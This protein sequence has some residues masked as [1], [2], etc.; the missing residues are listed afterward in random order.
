MRFRFDPEHDELRQVRRLLTESAGWCHAGDSG[1]LDS[2]GL[3]S[4]V[5]RKKDE[6]ISGGENIYSLEVEECTKGGT[7]EDRRAYERRRG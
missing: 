7:S 6:I 5:D 2:G 3:L 4:L 1:T